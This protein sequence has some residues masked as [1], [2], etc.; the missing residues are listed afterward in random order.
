[1]ALGTTLGEE[2]GA[3]KGPTDVILVVNGDLKPAYSCLGETMGVVSSYV[4]LGGSDEGSPRV[5]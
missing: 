3:I 5:E 4:C 2:V 1:M